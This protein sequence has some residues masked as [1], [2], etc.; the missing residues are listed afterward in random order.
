MNIEKH[1]VTIP[2]SDYKEL[3]EAKEFIGAKKL[4][5]DSDMYIS[6][7]NE[8]IKKQNPYDRERGVN[9]MVNVELFVKIAPVYL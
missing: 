2:V 1:T 7:R 6:V 8:L 3:L 5:E 4:D 9:P